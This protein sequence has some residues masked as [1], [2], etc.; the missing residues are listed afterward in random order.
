MDTIPEMNILQEYCLACDVLIKANVR[1]LEKVALPVTTVLPI[2]TS[3]MTS[4]AS[5]TGTGGIPLIS[6]CQVRCG[7]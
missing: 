5:V 7:T 1:V 4:S 3:P 2:V 6:T